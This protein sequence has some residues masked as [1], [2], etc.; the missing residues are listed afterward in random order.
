MRWLTKCIREF[1]CAATYGNSILSHRLISSAVAV[2]ATPTK[3][4]S[5]GSSLSD[6]HLRSYQEECI[7]SVLSYLE[8]G[9]KRLGVSLATG[10]GKTLIDRIPPRDEVANRTLIIVHRKELVEQ[11][12]KHCMLAY[13][14]KTIEIEMGKSHAT[15]TAEI[16]IASIRSLLSKG[17][18]EKFDPE[19]YK[20]ILVDEAHHIVAPSYKEVLG[21]FGLNEVSDGSP[22]LV[23]VSAT[24]SR[25]DG[26]KL[27]AA[28][29][30][31]VYHKDYIDMIGEKWLADAV[32][33]TVNSRADLS[34][35]SNGPNG[36]FQTGQLSAAVNT[37]TVNDITVRAWLS[38]ASE[39]KSTLVFGVNI[40]HVR[41]LT[42]AFRR[43]G[44]DARYITSQTPKDIRTDELEAFRN[45]EYPVL[46][47]CG[48]F[49][50]GT[51]IPNIDCVL[52]ARP[53]RSK[54]LL[55][56]MI[57]RGLRL[58]PGKKNCHIID[59]VASL[60]T[61]ITS[62]PT[63]FG[64]HPDEGL[65]EAKMEDI[66][67][68]KNRESYSFKSKLKFSAISADKVAVDFTDYDSVHDLL[69]DTSGER[70]I[71]SLSQNAWVSVA[72]DRYVLNA[73]PGRITIIKDD[74]AKWQ[75]W[76]KKY[77]SLGQVAFLN[78]HLPFD[79]QI[80]PR[81]ITKGDA[82]DMITKV[83]HGAMGQFKNIVAIKRRLGRE[84]AKES[85]LE[86]LRSREE[87]K[88]HTY[89]DAA[90]ARRHGPEI[91]NDTGY[92]FVPQLNQQQA[93][94]LSS[95]EEANPSAFSTRGFAGDTRQTTPSNSTNRQ[96]N[97]M[98]FESRIFSPITNN[99]MEGH[100]LR[101]SRPRILWSCSL[102]TISLTVLS[103]ISLYGIIH[104]YMTRQIDP[105]GCK[106]PRMMPTYIQLI[107]FDT[108]HTRFASKY[109]LYLYRER[110]VDKYSEQDIGVGGVPVLFLPGNAGS[111]RQGRSLASEASLY[112][113]DAISND[114][115]KLNAG[116]R[117]L[118][119]FMA[120]FNEDMAAFHGQTLLDQAEYVNEALAY[121]LSLYHDPTRPGRDLNLPDP[122]SVILIGHSMGGIV[123]R[124][125]LTMSNYQANS[126]NTIITMSTPHARPPV[127]FD[128]DVVRTYKQI[129]DYWREAYSQ[130]W[131]NN[132]PLWHVTLIS[133]AGGGGDSIVPSDYTSLS[134]LVPE[135]H[136]FTVFTSTIPNVWTGMDHLS[137]AWCD[138]FRKVIIR[139]LFDLVDV[140]RSSQTKQ[141][142]ERMSVFKKWYLTG[143]EAISERS[144]PQKDPSTLLTLEDNTNSILPQGQ[145]LVLRAFGSR[146]L[147]EAH[148]LPIPPQGASGKKFTLLTDQ[149]LDSPGGNG[150][151]EVLFCSVF[152]LRAGHSAP[153]L[154]S[155][156]DLSGGS[157]GSTRLACKSAME[158]AI[159]LPAST[160]SSKFAFDDALPFSYLQYNLE[161][162]MEHQF[163]AVID[164]AAK[165]SS[166]WLVAEFSDSSD[167]L[168]QT[169]VGLGRL[170]ATGLDIRLP[171]E[172]P[173]LTEVKIPALHSSLLAYKLRV[174]KQP[175]G[176]HAEL[177]TPLLRQYISEPH[178]S[179]YFVNVKEADINLHGVAPYMPPHLR[180]RSAMRGI[181]F[182]LWSDPSCNAS[183]ELSL[184]VDIVGSMG[185]LA[186]RYRTV[187]AA[188]PLLVT[189]L[190]LRKQF[191]IHDTT[192]WRSN[193]T[194]SAIDFT[195]N[196]L[197]LGSQ[198]S[199]FWFLVPLFGLISIG[200]CVVV[201]HVVMALI[202]GLATIRSVLVSRRGYIKHDDPRPAAIYPSLSSRQRIINSAVLLCFV[203]TVIPYQ[204]AYLVACLVQLA[205]CVQTLQYAR[206]SYNFYNYVHSIFIL[207]LWILPVNVPVFAVWVHNLAVHWWTP[208]SSHHNVLSIMPFILL[209]ETLT[210][211]H[212]IPRI[213]SR[214]RHV[215]SALFIIL[216]GYAAL[217]GVTY[218]YLLHH[219]ANIVTAWLV[220]VHF[221]SSGFSLRSLNQ[222]FEGSSFGED[223][224]PGT[225]GNIKKLP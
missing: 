171:A 140:R 41:C 149:L 203:A 43:F 52:L 111:Y 78:K 125:V 9:H 135:T 172:R 24:F 44:V 205:T 133:I 166:G 198:D 217:Y 184:R 122:S 67:K 108:E 116:T 58:Y 50:E 180:D 33:T 102:L 165:R 146:Q 32:F 112:F 183:T 187:F 118:D 150:K 45:Q 76:R 74:S 30:H 181:S 7:Q 114:Q 162:L 206:E 142:A 39:R 38:R 13:P 94:D 159:N 3:S 110:T 195:R 126:V 154:S 223:G 89:L 130:R 28:I 179:K 210:N 170:L 158:D 40:E 92:L 222:A 56:Q 16:T 214:L 175:C 131:A 34:K 51:D 176:E 167:A 73:P 101:R 173:M 124:T 80:K 212:M 71:R 163:V 11:A 107:G 215:T 185:K 95:G 199:F 68:L 100:K 83:K 106:T 115:E 64:L 91:N 119:F 57:G 2:A 174:G 60:G 220:G 147:P 104:S 87:V 202:Y 189:A 134:S 209:V 188:L 160:R 132:N 6:F 218:A 46:V 144:L 178:E 36:D 61:G 155:N 120:D 98:S 20:L 113:Q 196:D 25:F 207:M 224:P 93:T 97:A 23:G 225:N 37:D 22:A 153:L 42:E 213:T 211:G 192:D 161:D 164:K 5:P 137:I 66:E 152:P 81:E 49:T 117:S 197:L 105:Q 138:S 157:A 35:V 141:R 200:L 90:P 128:R 136:G 121:I 63:L 123:A 127:S 84:K 156:M 85:E 193:S 82:A 88:S 69:R 77:A 62:T 191:Q 201:N 48:L 194:E 70:H 216:A 15:G 168:I 103:A 169:K 79:S 4:H 54:N 99:S 219:I 145:R 27:G 109:R 190:V 204:F 65:D 10:S 14:G 208:F 8:K 96:E 29:D 86:E 19:R 31:I 1:K 21:Y 12:A 59:M 47:N 139:S 75:P 55:I 53:T 129:N 72:P 17:R 182:Q 143:M 186:M 221:A 26:L 151:L 148:L 177:F 18:I